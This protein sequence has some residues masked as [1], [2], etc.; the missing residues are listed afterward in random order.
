[1]VVNWLENHAGKLFHVKT[2]GC[3]KWVPASV[4]LGF[5]SSIFINNVEYSSNY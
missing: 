2:E 1:M 3:V 5:T 4:Y